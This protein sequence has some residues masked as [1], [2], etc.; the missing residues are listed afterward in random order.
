MEE[1][2]LVAIDIGTS[3]IAL[4]VAKVDGDNVQIV[5]YRETPSNGIK[6]SRVYIP[7]RASEA[8]RTAVREA[9]E[10]LGIKITQVIVGLPK[11]E[12][13]QEIATM[14]VTRDPGVC[15][16]SEEIGNIKD[17][18]I[19]TYPLENED[20]DMLF[21]AVA[22]SFSD[23]VDFQIVEHDV[24]GMATD[25]LDSYFKVFVG[26]RK[27][28]K[29]LRLAFH[30]A[31]GI[32]ISRE[33][34]T[35]DAIAKAVLYDSETENGVALIDLGAGVTSV[36]IYYGSIMRHY[37][38]IPFG[39]RS[40]TSDIKTE[41]YI[42]ERLAENIKLAYGA[43]MPEKLQNLSEKTLQI[44]SDTAVPVKQISVKYLS[45][46]ITA[47]VREIVDAVMYEIQESGFADSLRSGV[48]ITGGGANMLN[49]GNFIK[50]V[51]GYNVRTG[52]PKHTFSTAD[53]SAEAVYDPG[54]AAS[55]GMIM[56]AKSEN[57]NC[58]IPCGISGAAEADQEDGEETDSP[59]GGSGTAGPG[60]DDEGRGNLFGYPEDTP[61]TDNGPKGTKKTGKGTK[62]NHGIRWVKKQIGNLFDT[63]NDTYNEISNEGV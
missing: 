39:G 61:D 14:S 52:Y 32:C 40:I 17:M 13:R 35:P 3:K 33:Y 1:R 20:R 62:G 25:K 36:S 54:A 18:A 2:H 59:A 5:Y 38:T 26:Q 27:Y 58:L 15:I 28:V 43:C 42:P 23:G 45:E 53:E 11:Y 22:Q 34:F 29:D 16:T 50:D 10:E 47:R 19:E 21:G 63:I 8:I 48:V 6:F 44:N 30:N 60:L 57:I 55:V 7:G 12:V 4:T 46:I 31:D 24:I 9:E 37:A 49:I 51:S 41:C 56:M